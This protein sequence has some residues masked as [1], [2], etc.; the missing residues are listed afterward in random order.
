MSNPQAKLGLII[1]AAGASSRMGTPKQLLP[2]QGQPMLV[3]T[4]EAALAAPVWPVVVVLG[5][6]ASLIRPALAQLPV[7]VAENSAW[8]EGMASSIRTGVTTLQQFSRALTGG[9]IALCDQ[10]AFSTRIIETLISAQRSSGLSIV[11]SRYRGRNGAPALFL[12]EHFP[13]L[14]TLTGEEGARP[15][16]NGDS[17]RVATVDLP[18]LGLDL[19]TPADLAAFGGS[20]VYTTGF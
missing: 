12:Q 8:S 5:A 18:E 20:P 9:V 3:R 1:L 14:L 16:L 19:D 11:A 10:P 4:V 13:A 6:N 7:L 17:R 15:L 2:I